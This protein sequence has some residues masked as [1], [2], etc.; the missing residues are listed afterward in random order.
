MPPE[1]ARLLAYPEAG[2]GMFLSDVDRTNADVLA[3]IS[4]RSYIGSA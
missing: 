2:H 1:A 4:E 3:F